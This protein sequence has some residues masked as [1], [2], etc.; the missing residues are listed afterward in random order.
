MSTLDK[1]RSFAEAREPDD[2]VIR[3]G[4]TYG[5]ARKLIVMIRKVVRMRDGAEAQLRQQTRTGNLGAPRF[6]ECWHCK[7]PLM[8]GPR[9]R[10]DFCPDECTEANCKA[11]GCVDRD[12]ACALHLFGLLG[13]DGALQAVVEVD[14]RV[15]VVHIS[16]ETWASFE[17]Q[18]R[19]LFEIASKEV[20]R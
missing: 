11:P 12:G 4:L 6:D 19:A 2:A 9:P 17:E 13:A 16:R 7:T 8:P 3:G 1:L 18:A 20:L 10:C 5:D 15:G 14:G